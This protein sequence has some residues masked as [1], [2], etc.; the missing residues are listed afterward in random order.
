MQ[1]LTV[2]KTLIIVKYVLYLRR[3]ED[4]W[5]CPHSLLT[6]TIK[7]TEGQSSPEHTHTHTLSAAQMTRKNKKGKILGKRETERQTE[8][9]RKEGPLTFSHCICWL[10]L[11]VLIISKICSYQKATK[12]ENKMP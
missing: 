8:E 7:H 12:A 1:R 6:D 9:D 2:C 3:L 5:L 4:V 11:S 10:F